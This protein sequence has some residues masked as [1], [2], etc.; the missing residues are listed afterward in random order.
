MA[1]CVPPRVAVALCA[2]ALVLGRGAG[3]DVEEAVVAS[4]TPVPASGASLCGGLQSGVGTQTSLLHTAAVSLPAHV[5]TGTV[6]LNRRPPRGGCVTSAAVHVCTC[7]HM[8]TM[9]VFPLTPSP[10]W[11]CFLLQ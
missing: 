8:C 6:R 1:R 9:C 11:R 3:E 5:P 7:V 10:L 2:L 4:P